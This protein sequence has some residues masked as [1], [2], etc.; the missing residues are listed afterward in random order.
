MYEM[1]VPMQVN[2]IGPPHGCPTGCKIRSCATQEWVEKHALGRLKKTPNEIAKAIQVKL[3]ADY[4]VN[5]PYHIVW[6]GKERAL[7]TLYGDWDNS[8]RLLYNFKAEIQSRYLGSVLEIYTKEEQGNI[9]FNRFLWPLS[10]NSTVLTS[11]W[12]DYLASVTSLDG[13]NW[14]FPVA[15]GLFQSEIEEN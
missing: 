8:F 6:K 9:Y 10:I 2:K 5:L 1:N 12:Y 14:M 7:K 11:R 3:M 4:N 13:H 15:F